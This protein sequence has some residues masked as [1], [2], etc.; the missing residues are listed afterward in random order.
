MFLAMTCVAIAQE[1]RRQPN[2]SSVLGQMKA[3]TW[4]QRSDAFDQAVKLLES[5]ETS[6]S[7]VD[8]LRLGTIQL[9]VHE[10]NGGLKEPDNVAP[11]NYTEGYGEDKAEYYAGLISFVAELNDE[12]AIP[13]LLGAAG[14][15]G[16]ATRAVARFG[17]RALDPTL[18]QLKSQNSDL[19][20]GASFV[21]MQI[22]KLHTTSD[23]DSHLRIKDALK[24]AL[25]SPDYRTRANAMYP[26][27]YLDDRE[28]FVAILQDIAAHDSYKSPYYV[29]NEGKTVGGDYLVRRHAQLLLHKIESHEEPAID[30]GQV[31]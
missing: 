11:E 28:E 13:A 30:R 27:E 7:D 6:P 1:N 31:Q 8:R 17:K 5:A 19:A 20:S 9:L 2:I 25:V 21:V 12:R 22:L 16:M 10:N 23:S 4:S 29:T 18:T 24:S 15:G 14:S 3:T 26:V